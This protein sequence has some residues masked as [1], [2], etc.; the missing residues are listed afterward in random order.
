MQ[1]LVGTTNPSK[2]R[3]FQDLLHDY[4]VEFLTLKDKNIVQS[5]LET[6]S[7]PEENARIKARFYGNFFDVV[8]CNDSGLYFDA[9]PLSDP[10]QPGLQIRTP[11][12]RERLDDEAMIAYYADLVRSLGGRVLAYYLDGIAV[13]YKGV[14]TSF[15][16]SRESARGS[17]FYMVDTPSPQRHIGWPLDSLSLNRTTLAYFTEQGNLQYDDAEEASRLGRYRERLTRFLVQ[18]LHIDSGNSK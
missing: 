13:Y 10:R 9:L 3:R 15:M 11:Q 6:G 4:D 14:L 2:V 8:L 18:A 1:V 16:E 5:P 12:G 17:A 7:T